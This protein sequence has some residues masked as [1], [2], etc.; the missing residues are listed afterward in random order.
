[1]PILVGIRPVINPI[2]EGVHTDSAAYHWVNRT[3][4]SAIMSMFPYS[5]VGWPYEARSPH[6]MSYMCVRAQR[7]VWVVDMV[8]RT[9]I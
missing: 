3:P 6:P 5:C 4:W 7:N 8:R 1:M 9:Q 2:R